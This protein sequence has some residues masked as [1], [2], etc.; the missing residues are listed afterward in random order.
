MEPSSDIPRDSPSP[1]HQCTTDLVRNNIQSGT[2][3]K[4]RWKSTMAQSRT[5]TDSSFVHLR[6]V[7]VLRELDFHLTEM[8]SDKTFLDY[9]KQNF[10]EHS[11]G[12]AKGNYSFEEL[13]TFSKEQ[14]KKPLHRNV[15]S[16][17][18]LGKEEWKE[19]NDSLH[20]FCFTTPSM[21]EKIVAGKAFLQ[22][23]SAT[24]ELWDEAFVL[25]LRLINRNDDLEMR[26]NLWK[27]LCDTAGILCPSRSL[28]EV[29]LLVVHQTQFMEKSGSKELFQETN[30]PLSLIHQ[31]C[32]E[33]IFR[34]FYG[35]HLGGYTKMGQL[36]ICT[37]TGWDSLLTDVSLGTIVYW[38]G[39]SLPPKTDVSLP[40]SRFQKSFTYSSLS[41]AHHQVTPSSSFKYDASHSPDW[42]P[43]FIPHVEYLVPEV[44]VSLCVSYITAHNSDPSTPVQVSDFNKKDDLPEGWKEELATRSFYRRPVSYL[45]TLIRQF[46]K[47][48]TEP[49]IPVG[50]GNPLTDLAE[51]GTVMCNFLVH[52]LC[53]I[54]YFTVLYLVRFLRLVLTF[55]DEQAYKQNLSLLSFSFCSLFFRAPDTVD[56]ANRI[57]KQRLASDNLLMYLPISP[58]YESIFTILDYATFSRLEST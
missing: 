55:C 16:S 45:S 38:Q 12:F 20:A 4:F 54:N 21:S 37:P 36:K 31:L 28:E 43:L 27:I 24:S 19:M 42:I 49:L 35:I 26:A 13:I 47:N 14:L 33:I 53:P 18:S 51:K 25:I 29:I 46:L 7:F 34:L 30:P 52:H 22:K 56:L 9:A 11:K 39:Y 50:F 44:L 3:P 40:S 5:F 8:V 32:D 58:L 41:D 15:A 10:C 57:K 2:E 17:T 23:A 48:L 6:R 1:D